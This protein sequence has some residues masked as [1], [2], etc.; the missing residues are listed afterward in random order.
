MANIRVQ[1]VGDEKLARVL[2]QIDPGQSPGWVRR[3]LVRA[4]LRV[5]RNAATKQIKR[6]GKGAPLPDKLTSRTGTGRRSI[7]V[8]RG[9]L[10]RLFVDVGSDLGYMAVHETGGTVRRRAHSRRTQSGGLARVSAHTA[11]FPARPW[12]QPA[13][14]DEAGGMEDDLAAEWERE[15]QR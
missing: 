15:L 7:R 14:E 11:T 13:L 12:L 1:L 5:Q 10:P 4:G 8:D 3:G 6:G 9:G 2:E